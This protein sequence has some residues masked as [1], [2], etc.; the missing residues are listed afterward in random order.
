M[1]DN[2][3]TI[4]AKAALADQNST[5]YYYQKL[6]R[7]RHELP[8]ITT[9]AYQLLDPTD[10]QVYSY[11]RVGEKEELLVINNFTSDTLTRDYQVPENATVLISNYDDDAATTLR[12]YEAK[13]YRFSK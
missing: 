8:I 9:G 5:F 10:D 2:Y 3:E 6:I 7:L 4:N 13:V 12:P 1:N 11:R